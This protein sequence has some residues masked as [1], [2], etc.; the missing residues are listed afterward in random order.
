MKMISLLI[1]ISVIFLISLTSAFAGEFYGN[2]Y[3]HTFN[4]TDNIDY[5]NTTIFVD[6]NSTSIY[7]GW[8]NTFRDNADGDN[9]ITDVWNR[10]ADGDIKYDNSNTTTSNGSIKIKGEVTNIGTIVKRII[11]TRVSF[12]LVT[13]FSKSS[14][15][16]ALDFNCVNINLCPLSSLIGAKSS[17]STTHF[18]QALQLENWGAVNA[19]LNNKTFH[20]ISCDGSSCAWWIRN[21]SSNIS[22]LANYTTVETDIKSLAFGTP[23]SID[24]LLYLDEVYSGNTTQ[25]NLTANMLYFDILNFTSSFNQGRCNLN[26]KESAGADC[27]LSNNNGSTWFNATNKSVSFASSTQN[28]LAMINFTS[29]T[30]EIFDVNFTGI[31]AVDSTSPIVNTTFNKTNPA[32]N[33]I[34]NFTANITDETGLFSENITYN[35]SGIL[36]KVNFTVSGTR[37]EISNT[38]KITC[39]GCVIN[40]TV[41]ATDTSNNVKQNST[42]ITV[43]DTVNPQYNT[44]LNDTS[45]ELN[46]ITNFSANVSDDIGLSF[47]QFRINKTNSKI[48]YY[49][50]SISGLRASCWQNFTIDVGN[51]NVINFTLFVNDTSNNINQTDYLITVGDTTAPVLNNCSL[52]YSTLTDASG[53]TNKF[54]CSATDV[55]SNIQTMSF[56]INGT[57]SKTISFSFVQSKDIFPSYTIF[58]SVETLNVGAYSIM[59][60]TTTDNS[61]NKLINSTNFHWTVTSAPSGGGTSGGGGGGGGSIITQTIIQNVTLPIANC[62]FNK[63][64]EFGEDFLGC[65]EDCRTV[66]RLKTDYLFCDDPTKPCITDDIKAIFASRNVVI[67]LSIFVIPILI[68]F[69][70]I[71]KESKLGKL[72]KVPLLKS[73]KKVK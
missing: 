50:I 63:I 66:D 58:Q 35:I 37:A 48:E 5:F 42:L 51:D 21:A 26:A 41:Y 34:I 61:G 54:N 6:F 44:S 9:L 10:V 60:V 71:S 57:L 4:Y 11:P 43:T 18:V 23:N 32:L 36:T 12:W 55:S 7:M 17:I 28:L 19:P 2:T 73:F 3:L 8:N 56:D 14:F 27:W 46:D 68:A 22:I 16:F 25:K 69:V 38:T 45:L 65:P 30:Q 1:L 67:R 33:D 47:C 13:D 29:T 20:M 62:N 39:N 72:Y 24:N 64:C 40:F 49:N 70:F 52:Q 15:E 31:T 53:N 59:N